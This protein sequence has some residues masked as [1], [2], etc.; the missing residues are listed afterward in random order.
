MGDSY[1]ELVP[2]AILL[3]NP[4][5]TREQF[6]KRL[7][8]LRHL[9]LVGHNKGLHGLAEILKL[10]YTEKYLNFKR[11]EINKYDNQGLRLSELFFYATASSDRVNKWNNHM[12]L[13]HIQYRVKQH[14]E[15]ILGEEK[16]IIDS[17]LI[18]VK[19]NGIFRPIHGS[20]GLVIKIIDFKEEGD[21]DGH[22]LYKAELIVRPIREIGKTHTFYSINTL[23]KDFPMFHPDFM[24]DFSQSEGIISTGAYQSR[25]FWIKKNNKYYLDKNKTFDNIPVKAEGAMY[26]ESNPRKLGYTDLILTAEG[27]KQNYTPLISSLGG[28]KDNKNPLLE[29]SPESLARFTHAVWEGYVSMFGKSVGLT[30]TELLRYMSIGRFMPGEYKDISFYDKSEDMI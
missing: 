28:P 6:S 12:D 22:P 17:T 10:N 7:F 20:R 30:N 24:F 13:K 23:S 5:L 1:V 3:D 16:K 11:S 29:K 27:I 8:D 18:P 4:G 14:L 21:F 26:N 25:C 15:N 2:A 19:E 9:G